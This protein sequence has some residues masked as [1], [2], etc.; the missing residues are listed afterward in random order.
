MMNYSIIII[1]G[2]LR[3]PTTMK[4]IYPNVSS[5]ISVNEVNRNQTQPNTN[6]NQTPNTN[7]NQTKQQTQTKPQTPTQTK[8][9]NKPKPK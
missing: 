1:M 8:P 3:S 5:D 7:P 2:S 6:P 4:K 9:N